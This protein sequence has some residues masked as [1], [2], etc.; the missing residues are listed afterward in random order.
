MLPAPACAGRVPWGQQLTKM[1]AAADAVRDKYPAAPSCHLPPV[2]T[3]FSM[4]KGTACFMQ[5]I[6]SADLYYWTETNNSS[7]AA[8]MGDQYKSM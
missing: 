6:C 4:K 1:A 5:Q 2:L 8:K 7:T 3:S